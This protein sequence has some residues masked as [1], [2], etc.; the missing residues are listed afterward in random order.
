MIPVVQRTFYTGFGLRLASDIALPEL[1]PDA[2]REGRADVEIRREDL[3]AAWSE[4]R[5]GERLHA[6]DESECWLNIPEVAVYRI[7]SGR[8]IGYDPAAGAQGTAVR[9]YLLGSCMGA[10]LIQRRIL[11]LH[12]SAVVIGGKAY[13]FVGES[14][15]GKSTLA[16]AF[17]KRGYPLLSDD[18]IPVS[19]ARGQVPAVLP[20]YPQQKLWRE[21]L[22][23]LGMNESRYSPIY[24]SKYAVPV[25]S[26]FCNE[27]IPLAGVFE[28]VKSDREQAEMVRL[29]GLERL[30][31][32]QYHTY[33]QFLIPRMGRVQWHFATAASIAGRIRMYRLRR[34]SAGFAV[35]DLVD[36]IMGAALPEASGQLNG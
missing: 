30:P 1:L 25:P 5:D 17:V 20:A 32:L 21:S 28:L 27:P 23:R 10:L 13:A 24:D 26:R 33:R 9:L 31:I 16:A 7:R 6:V 8:E 18:V 2:G 11:P 14:G 3:A 29:D 4:R 22:E 36:R 34:P 12:G 35:D 15:A 19:V